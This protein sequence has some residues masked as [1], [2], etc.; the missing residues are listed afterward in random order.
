VESCLRCDIELARI[1]LGLR[2]SVLF[3]LWLILHALASQTGRQGFTR[4][5]LDAALTSYGVSQV[6]A[7]TSRLLRRGHNLFWQ[8]DPRTGLIYATGYI[9]LCKRLVE[10]AAQHKLYDLFMTNGPGDKRDMYLDVSGTNADFE[11]SILNGWYAS[12]TNPTISREVL[13]LLF[14]RDARTL[15]QLEAR[16]G[17][18]VVENIAETADPA[19][20]PLRA[21]GDLRTDVYRTIER[22]HTIYHYHLP[23][24]YISTLCK[25]HHARGQSRRAAYSFQLWIDALE[26]SGTSPANGLSVGQ[27]KPMTRLY[28]DNDNVAQQ[29][30]R[31]GNDGLLYVPSKPRQG[32]SIAWGVYRDIV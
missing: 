9:T 26:L 4:A 14:N 25:Q 2:Q 22:G 24:T 27:L 11:S 13:Q 17:I 30:R 10:H 23:N 21:N 18:Q 6:A 1:A 5:Q 28:C 15:R 31:R 29:A 7:Y 20:V 8:L 32:D 19:N 16:A 12:K 3:R